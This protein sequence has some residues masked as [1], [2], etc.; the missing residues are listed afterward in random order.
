[1]VLST[2]AFPAVSLGG[3]ECNRNKFYIPQETALSHSVH[4]TI[5]HVS[6]IVDR[7]RVQSLHVVP[8]PTG[9]HGFN[10]EEVILC[11]PDCSVGGTTKC[12]RY[13]GRA[14]TRLTYYTL[15]DIPPCINP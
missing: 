1:M 8:Q 4:E 12:L 6:S 11:W 15:K 3:P 13:F 9:A 5:I 2:L 14:A 7:H 10:P